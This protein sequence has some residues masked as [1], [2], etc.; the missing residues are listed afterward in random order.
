MAHYSHLLAHDALLLHEYLES[1]STPYSLIEFDVHVG[2][3]RDP[4]DTYPDNIRNM[5][6]HLSQR[7]ID[8]VG[9]NANGIDVIEVTQVADLKALGQL[10]AYPTLY[11]F[12]FNPSDIIRAVLVAREFGTDIEPIYTLANI[13]TFLFP[14]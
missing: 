2:Q 9:H 11:H 10:Q 13:E 12:Q 5:A 1:L 4:G 6:I 8:C 7:R 3:G 14:Q